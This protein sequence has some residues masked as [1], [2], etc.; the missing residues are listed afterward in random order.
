MTH[1]RRRNTIEVQP[2]TPAGHTHSQNMRCEQF[3][4]KKHAFFPPSLSDDAATVHTVGHSGGFLQSTSKPTVSDMGTKTTKPLD[5]H[6]TFYGECSAFDSFKFSTMR[7]YTTI[8]RMSTL[9]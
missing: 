8:T 4:N 1:Q 5:V 7:L 6:V 2:E 3:P 9:A